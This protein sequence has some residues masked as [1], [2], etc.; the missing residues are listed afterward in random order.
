M[1]V[2]L[3]DT[4]D[5]A[6]FWRDLAP[7]CTHLALTYTAPCSV[8][9]KQPTAQALDPRQGVFFGR[10]LESLMRQAGG[11]KLLLTEVGCASHT[12]LDSSPEIQ[13]QFVAMFFAWL[14]QSEGR[15]AAVSYVGL[16]D[17]PY[18]ATRG[19]LRQAFG[20]EI[21]QYRGLIRMLTSQGL[22]DEEGKNKP[23]Y[24]AFKK[25]VEQYRKR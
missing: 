11:R 18:E 5:P 10:T 8:L 24:D 25:A 21:L 20:D 3:K 14:R 6:K 12:S 15:V 23:A 17:W 1:G 16:K 9:T 4:N 19:M 2:V 7:A 22:K 13:A